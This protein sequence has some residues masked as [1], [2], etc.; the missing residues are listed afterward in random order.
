MSLAC[1]WSR[2]CH[3]NLKA[4]TVLL[5]SPCVETAMSLGA[6]CLLGKNLV[7]DILFH[8]TLSMPAPNWLLNGGMLQKVAII[9]NSQH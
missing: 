8:Y 2:L 1:L 6:A 3:V 7:L 5:S 9:N 4:Y